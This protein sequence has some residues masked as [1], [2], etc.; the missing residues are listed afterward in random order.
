M[1]VVHEHI[2]KTANAHLNFAIFGELNPSVW[3]LGV[4]SHAC[5]IAQPVQRGGAAPASAS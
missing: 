5:I 4:R 3:L 2:A 1:R